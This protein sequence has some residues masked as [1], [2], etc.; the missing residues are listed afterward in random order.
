[1]LSVKKKHESPV[2]SHDNNTTWHNKQCLT[3]KAVAI[4]SQCWF[5]TINLVHRADCTA[6][7]KANWRPRTF[8]NTN[9]PNWS[10]LVVIYHRAKTLRSVNNLSA[11]RRSLFVHHVKQDRRA[12]EFL[13]CFPP[14]HL[15]YPLHG[16]ATGFV[17]SVP[18]LRQS[19]SPGLH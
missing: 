12:C 16:G 14:A 4:A 7:W 18:A 11:P 2:I 6:F 3:L 9:D 8:R 19:S 1:M 17:C 5:F 10:C 13:L 15:I